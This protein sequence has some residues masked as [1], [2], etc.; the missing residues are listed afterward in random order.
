MNKTFSDLF[1]R[2]NPKKEKVAI[3]YDDNYNSIINEITDNIVDLISKKHLV[4]SENLDQETKDI[5]LSDQ[6]SI[7]IL[8]SKIDLCHNDYRI[9]S[10]KKLRKKIITFLHP[11]CEV[12]PSYYTRPDE[13]ISGELFD[14]ISSG[15][16]WRI[17]TEK[18]MDLSGLFGKKDPF[19]E[20][21]I[22]SGDFPF[23]EVGFGPLPESVNG[24]MVFDIKVQHIGYLDEPLVVSVKDD[25]ITAVEGAQA[26]QY[27]TLLQTHDIYRY[28]SEIAFGTNPRLTET[29][30]IQSIVEEKNLGT[31]HIGHGGQGSYGCRRG[32]HFD[33]VY[34]RPTFYIDD[35]LVIENGVMQVQKKYI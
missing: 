25:R 23:G 22:D 24:T 33:A 11:T 27:K 28:I 16:H 13:I 21:G 2:I 15:K 26:G 5:F 14:K 4:T 17:T 19:N 1:D 6:N 32:P 18:G 9:T 29:S 30:V 3:L 35:E 31:G 7:I 10:R 8:A 34:D 20:N 12:L